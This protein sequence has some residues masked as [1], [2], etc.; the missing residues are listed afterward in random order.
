MARPLLFQSSLHNGT[1][2]FLSI[3]LGITGPSFT[4]S[5]HVQTREESIALGKSLIEM[6]MVERCLVVVVEA[7]SP[8]LRPAMEGNLIDGAEA[9]LL[10]GASDLRSMG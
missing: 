5:Q 7:F 8:E 10:G 4:V 3:E 9:F 1:L 2:G 6:G